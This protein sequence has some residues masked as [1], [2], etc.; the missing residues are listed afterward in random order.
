MSLVRVC[1]EQSSSRDRE[2]EGW[3]GGW[4]IDLASVISDGRI[5]KDTP[6]RD[7]VHSLNLHVDRATTRGIR[8]GRLCNPIGKSNRG[9]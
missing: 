3:K 6:K 4:K 5:I 7:G 8:I 2:I 9:K 1:G